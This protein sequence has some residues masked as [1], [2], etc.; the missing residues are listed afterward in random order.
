MKKKWRRKQKKKRKKRQLTMSKMVKIY[1]YK[2]FTLN[3]NLFHFKVV[4]DNKT[5]MEHKCEAIF[6]NMYI[7]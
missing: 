3:G 4:R 5:F 2:N 1:F 7:F 6:K